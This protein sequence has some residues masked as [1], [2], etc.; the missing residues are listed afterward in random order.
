MFRLLRKGQT[1]AEY[2]I[3]IGLVVAVA[4]AMQ[5]Y[6]KRGVQGRFKDATDDYTTAVN[7]GAEWSQISTKDAT[8]KKQ[9]EPLAVSSQSTQQT[10]ED[11][12]NST[13]ETTG[14]VTRES[15]QRTQQK[16]GDYQ[17]YEY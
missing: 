16:A 17:K 14:T 13:M 15:T 8:L 2:A 4:V 12:A 9:Y 3:L 7:T 1:T 11:R 6:I 5:T 10:L